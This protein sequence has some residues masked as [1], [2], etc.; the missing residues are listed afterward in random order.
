MDILTGSPISKGKVLDSPRFKAHGATV[1]ALAKKGARVTIL[2]H[3]GRKGGKDFIADLGMHAK[4]LERHSGVRIRYIDGLFDSGTEKEISRMKDGEAVLLRNVRDYPDEYTVS[5]KKNR[6][7][8]FC[9]IFDLYVNDAFSVCHREQGSIMI[10]PKVIRAYAGPVLAREVSS[11]GDF[12]KKEKEDKKMVFVIGGEKIKDYAILL[13]MLKDGS[14]M[15]VGGVLADMVWLEKG[16]DLGYEK[17][18]L[19]KKGYLSY[20]PEMK[21]KIEEYKDRIIYPVDMAIGDS[22]RKEI[23]LEDLPVKSKIKD[24]GKKSVKLFEDAIKRAEIVFMKGPLGVCE[25]KRFSYGT[26]KLLRDVA[27]LTKKRKTYSLIGGG[28]LTDVI[29]EHKISGFSHVS[30]AGGALIDFITGKKLPGIEA[31]RQAR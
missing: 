9:K 7:R 14:K 23:G 8:S 13:K 17:E 4:I 22:K 10:P 31:L 11:L 19:E 21:K 2:A 1:G 5:D 16:L 24:I 15:A 30:L 29:E 3:Q 27:G 25:E 26:V 6:Y 20:Y 12:I 28:H 18:W